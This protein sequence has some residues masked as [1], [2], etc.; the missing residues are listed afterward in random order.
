MGIPIRSED[1]AQ[2]FEQAANESNLSTWL[3]R[4][5]DQ[6]SPEDARLAKALLDALSR[7]AT[8]LKRSQLEQIL[9]KHNVA[10]EQIKDKSTELLRMLE[11]DGYL[12]HQQG[13]YGFR[14]PLLRMFWYKTRIA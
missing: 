4:L 14:S 7:K 1:L 11:S 9:A 2:A 12:L 13:L 5:S 10:L 8:G 6:L 3:E